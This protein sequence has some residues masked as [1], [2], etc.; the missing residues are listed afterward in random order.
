MRS[1][2]SNSKPKVAGLA[3]LETISLLVYHQYSSKSS[4]S[5]QQVVNSRLLLMRRVHYNHSPLTS[6][7]TRCWALECNQIELLHRMWHYR[8]VMVEYQVGP[9]TKTPPLQLSHSNYSNRNSK[10]QMK[11]KYILLLI[12]FNLAQVSLAHCL[13]VKMANK[14][15]RSN[16]NNRKAVPI[17]VV[18]LLS[19]PH[20]LMRVKYQKIMFT[21]RGWI[22]WTMHTCNNRYIKKL[23]TAGS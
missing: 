11:S 18:D 3:S 22:A 21:N 5:T 12:V 2:P 14:C 15:S 13:Q 19:P 7:E 9:K 8:R 23:I 1:R 20:L 17:R 6:V 4:C 10:L 16:V